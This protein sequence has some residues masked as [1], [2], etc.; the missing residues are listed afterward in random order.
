MSNQ[1]KV[2]MKSDKT[3]DISFYVMFVSLAIGFLVTLGY[4]VYSFFE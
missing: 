4:I 2:D 1:N 3:T